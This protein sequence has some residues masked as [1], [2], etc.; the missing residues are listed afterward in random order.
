MPLRE[1]EAA[2]VS[3]GEKQYRARQVFKWLHAGAVSF[4]EMTDLPEK[5]RIRL[6]D[7]YTITVPVLADKQVSLTDNTVKYLWSMADGALI[8]CV[9]MEHAHGNTICI[10][11][12]AGC[13]MGCVFCASTIGGLERDLSASEMTDQVLFT[14]LDHGKRLSNVVLMGIGEPLDNFD[15][16]VLFLELISH[17]SGMGIGARHITISTCGIV[18][19]IDK[20]AQYDVQSTLAVS[21]HAPD[22]ETRTRLMPVNQKHGVDRLLK[23]CQIYFNKTG[24]RISYEYAMIDGINDTADHAQLLAKKLK[25][26]G[27][28]LNIILLNDVPER[29]FKASTRKNVKAFTDILERGGI[30]FTIR[31]SLGADIDAACGQLRRIR[32]SGIGT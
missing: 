26:T 4:S 12:Q 20:L 11:S 27:S 15:N 28:H 3:A 10:S 23:A 6:D 8:E 13:R 9:V 14:Q 24:R 17:S 1:L 22:D 2:F 19:N 5:L 18:E 25:K 31:R 29:D 16:T 7:E 32:R 30:N 21:L